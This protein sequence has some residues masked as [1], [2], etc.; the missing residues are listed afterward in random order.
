[1][2][3]FRDLF[4]LRSR[5]LCDV[6]ER[7]IEA[8]PRLALHLSLRAPSQTLMLISLIILSLHFDLCRE[9]E[10]VYAESKYPLSQAIIDATSRHP[11]A[12]ARRF[13]IQAER[14]GLKIAGERLAPTL[15]MRVDASDDLITFADPTQMGTKRPTE[16][17]RYTLEMN[18]TQPLR[19]GTQFTLGFTQNLTD[20]NNIFRTCVP[21][22][23]SER[24]YQSQL[25]LSVTQPL[26]RGRRVESNLVE[27]KLARHGI[28]RAEARAHA[29]IASLAE[30]TAKAYATLALTQAQ[31]KLERQEL[32]LINRQI[33]EGEARVKAGMIA[34][35]DLYPLQMNRAQR[36]Q[37]LIELEVR[38]QEA[39]RSLEL[40]CERSVDGDVTM[41]SLPQVSPRLRTESG[42]PDWERM[43]ELVTLSASRAQAEARL[44]PLIDQ[45]RP[46]LDLSLVWSQSGLGEALEEAISALPNNES[47]FYGATLTLSYPI[48]DLAAHR[49]AQSRAQISSLKEEYDGQLK[50]LKSS[51]D[52]VKRSREQLIESSTWA[53]RAVEASRLSWEASKGRL[54]EGRA[55]QFEVL[56]LQN[57]HLS[58]R[59]NLLRA[60]H[61]LLLNHFTLL[62][63]QGDLLSVFG[64][65]VLDSGNR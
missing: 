18:V 40:L 63:L 35:A 34:P 60:E 1:M 30:E 22:V 16:S 32:A 8:P 55:T 23:I 17:Q 49:V 48:S 29:E 24:C 43:P 51:W 20:S 52:Q 25:A 15:N 39:R 50:R 6:N 56:E 37:S 12:R 61:Q 9:S 19:W 13:D 33:T 27:V 10:R 21:G 36:A 64:V 2:K 11:Q 58:A 31:V 42:A 26:L 53:H 28:I 38:T 47:R 7:N 3:R 62:K 5:C 57:R 41:P 44:L 4:R 54:A 65:E 45:Q 59:F 46:Q 14:S